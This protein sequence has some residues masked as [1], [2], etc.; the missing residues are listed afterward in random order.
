MRQSTE[1]AV[2]SPPS[3]PQA[4]GVASSHSTVAY[5]PVAWCPDRELDISEWANVG[6]RF[7]MVNRCSAWWIGDWINY[8]SAKFGE[9]YSLASKITGYDAQTLMNMVYVASRFEISRRR[10]NLSWSHHETVASLDA[11][12]QDSW[13]DNAAKHKM[14]VAD[15][16]LELRARHRSDEAPSVHTS[17]PAGDENHD[18]LAS[19][20]CPNCGYQ[21]SR[22]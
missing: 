13:L 18:S 7:G 8:G 20:S 3:R 6:R 16:R 2:L 5:T 21:I 22:R 15:L 1:S 12:D 19:I 11:V 17:E 14:S 4:N 9:K 10:E